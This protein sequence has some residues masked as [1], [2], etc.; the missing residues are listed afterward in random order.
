MGDPF[1]QYERMRKLQK[2]GGRDDNLGVNIPKEITDKLGLKKQQY[3][4]IRV[5]KENDQYYLKIIPTSVI[6]PL[7]TKKSERDTMHTIDNQPISITQP[8]TVG[9]ESPEPAASQA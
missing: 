6:A 9:M 4:A 7:Q 8:S 2:I 1:E 3:V 5:E